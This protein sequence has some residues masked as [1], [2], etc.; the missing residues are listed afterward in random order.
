MRVLV[1]SD[2]HGRLKNFFKA[3][4]EVG[5]IDLLLHLGDVEGQEEE[6]AAAANCPV[7]MIAGNNDYFSI[8]DKEKEFVLCGKRIW[9][10]HGHR[11]LVGQTS[12]HLREEAK[13]RGVDLALFG[14][15]H[16]PR[17][18][19]YETFTIACPGSLSYPRQTGRMPTYLLIDI[20]HNGEFHYE[21]REVKE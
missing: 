21:I 2:T 8:L 3:L 20:D 18:S 12:A 11:Y 6:I 4:D 9:M 13:S 5:S 15:T 7:E 14:H 1:I 19:H 16:K 10:T 17:V